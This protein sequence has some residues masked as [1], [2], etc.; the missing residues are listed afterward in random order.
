MVGKQTI[1]QH[2]AM[3]AWRELLARVFLDFAG[4]DNVSPEWLVNPATRRRL[5]LDRYYQDAG[6]AIRF[7]GLMA[8]GQ[9]RQSDWDLLENQQRDQIRAELCRLNDVQ[10]VVVD[11]LEDPVKQL[12]GLLRMLSRAGRV[13]AQGD[14]SAAEKKRWMPAL[15]DA[16]RRGE[17]LRRLVAK[18]PQ[19]MI[20]NLAESWR[21]RETGIAAELSS[22]DAPTKST[23]K[24]AGTTTYRTGDRVQHANFGT[25]V[26][27]DL[28]SNAEGDTMVSVLFD[29]EQERTFLLSLV[30]GKM[31]PAEQ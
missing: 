14:R 22:D 26:I 29:A 31:E 2:I 13:L 11:P 20:V 3:N 17:E 28:S 6:V 9:R 10:L 4:Q 5:K 30:E 23:K 27:T 12:D 15:A 7:A 18:N 16:R 1:G 19:Q 8:K 21:D 25:G 24:S